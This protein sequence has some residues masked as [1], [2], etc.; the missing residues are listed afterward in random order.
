MNKI[1][2]TERLL[3]KILDETNTEQVLDYVIRNRE[4]FMEFE[5]VTY[6]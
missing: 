3:L 2:E 1:Y 4:F 6:W 5:P